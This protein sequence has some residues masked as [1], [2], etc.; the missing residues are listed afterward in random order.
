MS[1]TQEVLAT[2]NAV[3]TESDWRQAEIWSACAKD[4]KKG[5]RLHPYV[6]H[7]AHKTSRANQ[8]ILHE[9]YTVSVWMT[10]GGV[11][12]V[13]YRATDTHCFYSCL[14]LTATLPLAAV[15][16]GLISPFIASYFN[17]FGSIHQLEMDFTTCL[18]SQ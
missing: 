5:I 7:T 3:C 17:S 12:G 18:D 2:I 11:P 10:A 8:N 15:S 1:Y 13:C 14:C 9:V 16:S 6:W 4:A